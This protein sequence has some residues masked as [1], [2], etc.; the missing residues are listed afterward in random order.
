M[1]RAVLPPGPSQ[2]PKTM[3]EREPH[4]RASQFL[5]VTRGHVPGMYF[6]VIGR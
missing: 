5:K 2:H 6:K 4:I 3:R 1:V